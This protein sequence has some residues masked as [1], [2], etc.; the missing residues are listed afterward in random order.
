MIRT[1]GIIILLLITVSCNKKNPLRNSVYIPYVMSST[2]DPLHILYSG[3]WIMTNHL[4]STLFDLK[5]DGSIEPILSESWSR[6]VVGKTFTIKLKE[7]LKWSDGSPMTVDQVVKSLEMSKNGTSHTDLSQSIESITASDNR[8]IVFKLK[9]VV[10]QFL[11]GLT[12]SDWAIIHQDSVT[13]K[14]GQFFVTKYEK[15]SG[16]YTFDSAEKL[17]AGVVPAINLLKNSNHPFEKS[18]LIPK[19]K[20]ATYERCEDLLPHLSEIASF[21]MYKDELS[22]DCRKKLEAADFEFI[23]SQPSWI[24]KADFTKHGLT[25]MSGEERKSLIV[26]LQKML[27][28]EFMTIGSSRA[29]G[30]RAS[31]L[32]GSLPEEEFDQILNKMDKNLAPLKKQ[33]IRIVA[34]DIWTNWKSYHW[35]IQALKKLGMDVE[36]TKLSMKDFYGEFATGKVDTNYELLFIPLGVGDIDPDGSWRIASRYFYSDVISKEELH[37]AYLEADRNLRHEKYKE[38]AK[39]LFES[40]R[41]IPLT[42]NSDIIGLHKD[43]KIKEGTALRNGTSL[44]D[45]E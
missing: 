31:H 17:P 25:S 8:T 13:T 12:Y 16:P 37:D 38:F 4:W 28:N 19:G 21:R 42:M 7:N 22:E 10:P 27:K 6:S 35:L 23:P 32:Y 3:D 15:L 20:V 18:L 24:I 14:D 26:N 43:F 44:Y 9:T 34:M 33:K 36:E 29:T 11:E 2:P 39:K 40:A 41:Y 5:Y 45:L 30:L 1:I